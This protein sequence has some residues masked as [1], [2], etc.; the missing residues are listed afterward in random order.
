MET[1]TPT[2]PFVTLG[3]A[4][5]AGE[6]EIRA[7]YLALVKQFPPDREPAKFRDIRG[8]FEAARDPLAIAE[9]LLE[10]PGDDPPDWNDAIDEQKRIPPSISLSFLLSLGNRD[11]ENRTPSQTE[12]RN[13]DGKQNQ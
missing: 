9:R 6:E 10:P 11:P 12:D 13:G 4:P 2:D 7:R 1:S 3:V 5:E 8:A